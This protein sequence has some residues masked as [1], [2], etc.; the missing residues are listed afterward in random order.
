MNTMIKRM[1]WAALEEKIR[2]QNVQIKQLL[3]VQPLN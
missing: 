2:E 1:G 3:D